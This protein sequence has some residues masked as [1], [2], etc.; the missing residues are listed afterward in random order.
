MQIFIAD[1]RDGTNQPKVVQEVLAGLKIQIHLIR[2]TNIVDSEKYNTITELIE[3]SL[4]RKLELWSL[5]LKPIT[6]V[7]QSK[8]GFHRYENPMFFKQAKQTGV[9]IS[10]LANCACWFTNKFVF[11][12]SKTHQPRKSWDDKLAEEE[13]RWENVRY[14]SCVQTDSTCFEFPIKKS[15]K[16]LKRFHLSKKAP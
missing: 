6:S 8:E 14:E 5:T 12:M 9:P 7:F 11:R 4:N 10:V 3:V 15:G 16:N 1:E 13:S 2:G